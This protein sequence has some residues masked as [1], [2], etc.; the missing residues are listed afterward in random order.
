[1]YDRLTA[2]FVVLAGVTFNSYLSDQRRLPCTLRCRF[3]SHH[4]QEITIPWFTQYS[5]QSGY[6]DGFYWQESL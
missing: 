5:T 3:D 2:R 1:M 6:R 4:T